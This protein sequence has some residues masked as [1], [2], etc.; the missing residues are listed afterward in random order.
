[1]KRGQ[2]ELVDLFGGEPGHAR[3]GRLGL[4]GDLGQQGR[5]GAGWAAT[6]CG[7]AGPFS[8]PGRGE[9]EPVGQA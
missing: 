5:W 4:A 6:V 9:V 8:D 3:E 7:E 2:D 1:V